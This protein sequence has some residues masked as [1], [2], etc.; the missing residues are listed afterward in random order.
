VSL[1]GFTPY[2]FFFVP[3]NVLAYSQLRPDQNNKASSL[4]SLF[5]NWGG[6]FGIAF[7]TTAAERRHQL[8]QTNLGSAIGDPSL[9]LGGRV[10]ALNFLMLLFGTRRPVVQIHSPRPFFIFCGLKDHIERLSVRRREVYAIG[11]AVQ[12]HGFEELAPF[13]VIAGK[14]QRMT[15]NNHDQVYSSEESRRRRYPIQR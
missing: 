2:G 13:A 15:T 5:R 10:A 7:I 6:S 4:T 1:Q 9:Q 14:V 11:R 3:V 8:H 12:K